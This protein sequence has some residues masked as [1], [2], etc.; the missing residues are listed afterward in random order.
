LLANDVMQ[1]RATEVFSA[2]ANREGTAELIV[3][4]EEGESQQFIRQLAGEGRFDGAEIITIDG[5]RA[6]YPNGWGLVRSSNTVPGLSLRFEADSIEELH[7]I[8]QRFKQQMLQIKPT[9]ILLF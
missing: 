4:M 8:Q 1:R 3:E 2:L 9:L 5:V 6:E 7:D